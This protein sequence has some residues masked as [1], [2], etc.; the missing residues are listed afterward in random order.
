VQ[1][2]TAQSKRGIFRD[3]G[4]AEALRVFKPAGLT[5]FISSFLSVYSFCLLNWIFFEEYES[6]LQ[7]SY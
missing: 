1:R 6:T 2:E 4:V 5:V 7:R 3:Y